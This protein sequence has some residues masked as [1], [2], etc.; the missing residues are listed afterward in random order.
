MSKRKPLNWLVGKRIGK[1]LTQEELAD[2]I[3]MKR[4][5]YAS[6]EQGYRRASVDN[7]KTIANYFGFEWP[8]FFETELHDSSS[9][10][11]CVH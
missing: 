5:T 2:A 10:D 1:G 9:S 6:I 3:G 8:I 11:T 7:A 4:T